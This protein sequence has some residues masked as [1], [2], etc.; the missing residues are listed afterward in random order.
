MFW[1][2]A[3]VWDEAEHLNTTAANGPIFQPLMANEW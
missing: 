3:T 2:W 1:K